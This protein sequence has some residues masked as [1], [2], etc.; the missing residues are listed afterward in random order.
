[1]SADRSK[2]IAELNDQFRTALGI[3]GNRGVPGQQVLTRGIASLNADTLS[4]VL[5]SVVS[6]KDFTEDN[7]PHGEHDFGAFDDADAGKVFWKI[8]YY[9]DDRMEYGSEAPEDPKRS[10]RVLT[11]MVADEW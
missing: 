11:I 7:D 6:F 3:P 9:A 2:R 5:F 4:R 10:Y 1:M 8:D